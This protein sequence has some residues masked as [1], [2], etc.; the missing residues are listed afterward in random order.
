VDQASPLQLR[1]SDWPALSGATFGRGAINGFSAPIVRS[2]VSPRRPQAR[3]LQGM[4]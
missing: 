2:A 3:G 4:L 1:R